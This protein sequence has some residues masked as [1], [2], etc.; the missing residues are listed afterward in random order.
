M[1]K[2]GGRDAVRRRIEA[3]ARGEAGQPADP[4]PLA[5]TT[6]EAKATDLREKHEQVTRNILEVKHAS[7]IKAL[8]TQYTEDERELRATDAEIAKLPPPADQP[9]DRSHSRR[10]GRARGP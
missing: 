2:I 9:A 7:L 10:A 4:N 3:L 5:C 6:L 8:E 1:N